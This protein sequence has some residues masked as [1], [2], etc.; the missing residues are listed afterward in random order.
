MQETIQPL[1]SVILRSYNEEKHIGKLLSSIFNQKCI[2]PFEV[3]LVDSG[4][5]DNTLSIANRYPV[6]I[7]EISP[8]EF[9]FG[10]SLNRGIAKARGEV[11]VMTSAHCY[12]SNEHWLENIARPILEDEK[13]ALVYGNQRGVESTR[14]SEHQ[15]FSQWFSDENI[16]DYKLPFC[17]NANSA[18][19]RSLWEEYPFNEDLTGLEDLDWAK[20]V[21]SRSLK[22]SYRADA[23]VFHVHNETP[24][25]I[26]QRYYREAYAFKQ[27]FKDE[28]FAFFSF[29]KFFLLN[30]IN[31]YI[32]AKK[33]SVILDNIL[34]IPMFRFLQF[35]ATYKAHQY[36]IPISTDMQKQLYYPKKRTSQNQQPPKSNIIDITAPLHNN[37]P[38]W[39]GS[40]SFTQNILKN[41]EADSF[42]ESE[43]AMNIHTGT[44]MDAP[45]HFVQNGKSIDQI[46]LR[47]LI[48]KVFVLEYN[49]N[50]HISP[51]YL[52]QQ[53]IPNGCNK[54]IFK[55]LNS[56]GE[57]QKTFNENFIAITS[58]TAD[59]LVSAG[60]DLVGIDGPSIQAFHDKNNLTH[61]I[62]LKNEILILEGLYLKE[63]RQ[64]L[65][66]L[67]ALPLLIE[68]AEGS[69][70][71]AILTKDKLI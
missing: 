7:V 56:H 24:K 58:H 37:L 45:L 42:H 27:I 2:Y 48:G 38:V 21:R 59:W 50:T 28:H 41:H 6:K 13:V 61:E 35:W 47:R 4:S 11:C 51:E 63:A 46:D 3:I 65:Y 30:T 31:D 68:N 18:I 44:H 49:D 60:M 67:I 25:Q 62:L 55:T 32:H 39:P 15:I 10:R 57:P 64:G 14:Y 40:I 16:Y 70:I 19:R 71:R 52:R 22:I 12:A 8:K 17:N 29:L 9:T 1:V 5:K 43:I 20:Y 33:D 54:I 36:N 69:P 34:S 53:N 66:N 26:Y 23:Q